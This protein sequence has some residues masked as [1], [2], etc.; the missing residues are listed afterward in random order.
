MK[1][2]DYTEED[3][4]REQEKMKKQSS[5]STYFKE[6]VP[7]FKPDAKLVKDGKK[8]SIDIIPFINKEGN[9]QA[10]VKYS[11]HGWE[12][13]NSVVCPKSVGKQCPIC[14]YYWSIPFQKGAT[15]EETTKLNKERNKYKPKERA[16]CNVLITDE[17]GKQTIAVY[18][19]VY[20]WFQE[21]VSNNLDDLLPAEK[22]KKLYPSLKSGSTLRCLFT[23]S[24]YG[25]STTYE[26]ESFDMVQ[27]EPLPEDLIEKA[28][29]L[30]TLLN[31]MDYETLKQK[32]TM[33]EEYE[34]PEEDDGEA[35]F[36]SDKPVNNI[37]E[38]NNT[39]E[40]LDDE[41]PY[42]KPNPCPNGHKFGADFNQKD[43]CEDCPGKK[44]KACEAVSNE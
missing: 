36:D 3:N 20:G 43:E 5:F 17:S 19:E 9:P 37:K 33:P 27:R 6:Q 26:L 1:F 29:K 40:V 18:D 14:E 8:I 22:W 32:F 24:T 31:V 39:K 7:F 30:D 35:P 13:F 25:K 11:K 38:F 34:E 4:N 23:A 16:M 21:K 15:P 2:K 10:V 42:D 12:G 44:F 41:I 28:Y